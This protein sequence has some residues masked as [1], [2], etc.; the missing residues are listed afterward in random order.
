MKKYNQKHTI[1]RLGAAVVSVSLL[2]AL[3]SCGP[4]AN[5]NTVKSGKIMVIGKADF[6]ENINAVSFWD[7]IRKGVLEAAKELNYTVNYKCA[8][9][10]DD[11]QTQ[12]T[13]IQEAVDE[14]YDAIVIAQ[15]SRNALDSELDKAAAKGIKLIS[16]DSNNYYSG[17]SCHIGSSNST[18]ANLA[19]S[20][21]ANLLKSDVG[22]IAGVGKVGI[23]SNT[24]SNN[25][26]RVGAFKTDFSFLVL[27]DIKNPSSAAQPVVVSDDEEELIDPAEAAK[28]AVEEAKAKGE[29]P[30]KAAKKAAEEAAKK[31]EEAT[32][33]KAAEKAEKQ[34][35][36]TNEED[37]VS[38]AQKLAEINKTY[39]VES[40][41]CLT[42]TDAYDEAYKMLSEE[43]NNIKVM[44]GTNT[45]TTIG[46]C[47]A[48]E[49]LGLKDDVI[50]VGFDSSDMLISYLQSGILD[51]TVLQNPYNIGYLAIA[52]S[53][54][55]IE[56]EKIP[57]TID[58]GVTIITKDDIGDPFTDILLYPDKDI[59]IPEP[60]NPNGAGGPP[61]EAE[62]NSDQERNG[63][64][65]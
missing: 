52:Y 62:K 15:N 40:D 8:D 54:K 45:N 55:L 25:E 26:E 30:A 7:D 49:K 51:A 48:V 16:I 20:E 14:N 21:A 50:V 56:E 2:S 27:N 47:K 6:S 61:E 17:F 59:K 29:D 3:A 41:K 65:K 39:Y 36:I 60:S 34:V 10:D 58:T 64:K 1:C 42:A 35:E 44:Y 43:G 32:L 22:K 33:K 53:K 31:L 18:A 37:Q 19:A 46:I 13:L 63:G 12:I 38:D 28:R 23:I 9:N 57:A 24:T 5:A 4:P 11:Y